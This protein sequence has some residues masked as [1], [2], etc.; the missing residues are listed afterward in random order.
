MKFKKIFIVASL[1]LLSM[2]ANAQDFFPEDVRIYINPGHGSWGGAS[3]RHM[4]TIGHYPISNEDPDTT[5]FYAHGSCGKIS[6]DSDCLRCMSCHKLKPV[7]EH[8]SHRLGNRPVD[9]PQIGRNAEKQ[10][11]GTGDFHGKNNP[12]SIR[13]NRQHDKNQTELS[14]RT[15]EKQ[16]RSGNQFK[17]CRDDSGNPV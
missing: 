11:K 10:N 5:D 13:T 3:N 16:K 8:K 12:G 17:P 6:K 14:D 1:A 7:A 9:P 4:A 15:E 2:G